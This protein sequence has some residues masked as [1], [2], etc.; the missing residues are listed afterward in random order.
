MLNRPQA[1]KPG[2]AHFPYHAERPPITRAEFHNSAHSWHIEVPAETF[3]D[4]A[5]RRQD[6]RR[7]DN[8]ADLGL[9]E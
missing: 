4:R 7:T 8:D 6:A 9:G 5:N 1:R 3:Q 2:T